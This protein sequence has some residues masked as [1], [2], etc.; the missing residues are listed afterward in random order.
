MKRHI[1]LGLALAMVASPASSPARASSAPLP[2]VDNLQADIL[3]LLRQR[4]QLTRG[5]I[6]RAFARK[7]W[8]NALDSL[9]LAGRAGQDNPF[10]WESADEFGELGAFFNRVSAQIA[11]DRSHLKAPPRPG[12]NKIE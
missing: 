7:S 9:A 4:G 12:K 6:Q 10:A 3:T 2:R 1:A 8:R 11:A 5:Q